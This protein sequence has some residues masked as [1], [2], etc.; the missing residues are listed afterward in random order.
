MAVGYILVLGFIA[1]K[2]M[3][4]PVLRVALRRF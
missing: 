1:L 4:C 2:V 3:E